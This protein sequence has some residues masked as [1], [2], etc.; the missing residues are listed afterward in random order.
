MVL[1]CEVRKHSSVG[2]QPRSPYQMLDS[3]TA[4]FLERMLPK[5]V[6]SPLWVL[7]IKFPFLNIC[8]GLFSQVPSSVSVSGADELYRQLKSSIC[9]CFFH[10]I[11]RTNNKGL[12]NPSILLSLAVKKLELVSVKNIWTVCETTLGC[13]GSSNCYQPSASNGSRLF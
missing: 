11:T 7:H 3:R 13:S 5:H 4:L 12:K 10:L 2:A 8:L 9:K 6:K 1:Q